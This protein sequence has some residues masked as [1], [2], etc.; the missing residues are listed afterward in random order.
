M[1]LTS[2][3]GYVAGFDSVMGL[4]E[5]GGQQAADGRYVR[6]GM[7]YRGS[8]LVGLSDEQRALVDGFDLRF[9]LDLRAEGEVVGK[10]DYVPLGAEYVRIAGMYD[11]DGLEVD[12]SP[13]GID[14]IVKRLRG[15]PE[16]FMRGRYVSMAFGNPAIHELVRRFAAGQAPL[17]F[18]CTAGKDRTGV[19]A[20]ILLTLLGVPD[21]DIVREFL[22]TNEYRAPLINMRPE[23]LPAGLSASDRENWAKINGVDEVDLRAVFAAID[24]RHSS[25]EAYFRDEFGIDAKALSAIRDRY[26]A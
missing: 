3:P 12:F 24:E 18:H 4:R 7:L 9:I 1:E 2:T 15:N 19:S 26:L 20:A 6:H 13:M 8:A 21:D 5:L 11:D 14:R 22:L 17:Y 10:P 23:E 25:R 16:A